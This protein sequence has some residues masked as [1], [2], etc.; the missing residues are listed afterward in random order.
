MIL[1]VVGLICCV[2]AIKELVSL[3]SIVKSMNDTV[4]RMLFRCDNMLDS[5]KDASRI[6]K[7]LIKRKR[8]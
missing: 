2:L 6:T 4:D 7:N 1:I 3:R 8:K 5:L